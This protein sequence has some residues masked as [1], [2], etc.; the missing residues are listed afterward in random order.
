MF[1]L[2]I[3]RFELAVIVNGIDYLTL[4]EFKTILE[5]L[6]EIFTESRD[7]LVEMTFEFGQHVEAITAINTQLDVVEHNLK[8][9]TDA[10][11]MKEAEPIE[12]WQEFE[13]LNLHLVCLN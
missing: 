13:A 9:V 11:L 7:K 8:V 6:K 4:V 3:T 5:G 2:E 12:H 1:D 10:M